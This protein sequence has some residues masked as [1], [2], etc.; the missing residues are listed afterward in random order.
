MDQDSFDLAAYRGPHQGCGPVMGPAR[1]YHAL[2]H[3]ALADRYGLRDVAIRPLCIIRSAK[4]REGREL[5]AVGLK[6]EKGYQDDDG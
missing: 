6:A 3:V 1:G 5:L 4:T 2:P